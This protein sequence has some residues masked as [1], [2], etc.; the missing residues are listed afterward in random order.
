MMPTASPPCEPLFLHAIDRVDERGE[1]L[2]QLVTSSKVLV[3]LLLLLVSQHL[4]RRFVTVA[5]GVR[6][7]D[8]H[9]EDAQTATLP[10]SMDPKVTA[11]LVDIG[12][13]RRRLLLLPTRAALSLLLGW[14]LGLSCRGLLSIGLLCG[15]FP[16]TTSS[17]RMGV[18]L[19]L[20]A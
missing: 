11:N 5:A 19:A 1:V 3:L 17:A 16:L 14:L 13:G 15:D 20:D 2:P 6:V 12:R 7:R 10:E 9:I 18:R 4:F 8:P